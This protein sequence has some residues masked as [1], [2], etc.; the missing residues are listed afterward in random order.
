MV[1]DL[2]IDNKTLFI[3][4]NKNHKERLIPI[5]D[6]VCEMMN[7][8]LSDLFEYDPSSKYLFP[9]PDG[10]PYKAKWLRSHFKALWEETRDP[11][12]TSRVRVYDLRHRWASAMMMKFLNEKE[13]LFVILPYMS[14]YMGHSN[15]EDTA[16]Y[17]HLIPD[18]LLKS[19][20]IDWNLFSD[21][22]PEVIDE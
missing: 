2:N 20:S 19:H 9:S 4:K 6:D 12:N 13:D 3:R 16:Y 15:F 5:A 22:L 7:D 18:N 21:L 1:D 17:V 10:K 8:Y 11:S 14:S